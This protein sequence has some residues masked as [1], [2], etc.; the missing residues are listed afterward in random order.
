M[1]ITVPSYNTQPTADI[2]SLWAHLSPEERSKLI[3]FNHLGLFFNSSFGFNKI[4]TALLL[5]YLILFF[6]SWQLGKV[7]RG[8][9]TGD[10]F[11]LI[12][13]VL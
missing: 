4:V 2:C 11:P 10:L 13:H 12:R 8:V 9:Y 1:Y 5:L 3:N 6:A 7:F